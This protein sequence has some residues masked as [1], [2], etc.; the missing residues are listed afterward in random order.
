MTSTLEEIAQQLGRMNSAGTF[1]THNTRGPKDLRPSAE[2]VGRVN[3]PVAPA[4]TRKLCALA[5]PARHGRCSS[6]RP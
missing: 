2:G 4:S 3:L 5:Q 1:A 6:R